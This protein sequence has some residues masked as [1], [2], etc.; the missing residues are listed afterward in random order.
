MAVR[1]AQA[2]WNGAFKEGAGTMTTGTG[3]S[4]DFSAST[5]FEDGQGS[6][7]EEL[8]GAAHAGCF[9][10][11]L[12]AGLGRNGFN[13]TRVATKANVHINRMEAGFRVTLIELVC[14]AVV[15]DIDDAKFQEIAEATK[16]G[17][18]ISAA[19]A[20]TPINLTAKLVSA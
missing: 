1:N 20:A 7:P 4:F 3:V 12:A 9:S 6:N 15:P 19:L 5:R 10:M 13:P 18:P 2:V 16:T 14:E 11:A 8:L 17:C